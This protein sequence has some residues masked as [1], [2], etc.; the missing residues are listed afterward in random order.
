MMQH[1]RKVDLRLIPI[2]AAV[3][4]FA[5]IDRTNIGAARISGIDEALNLEVGNRVSIL[6]KSTRSP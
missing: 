6:S 2:L 4:T 1:S 5:L 3:Y